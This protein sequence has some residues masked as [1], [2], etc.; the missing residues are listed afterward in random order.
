MEHNTSPFLASCCYL[1][2]LKGE[3]GLIRWQQHCPLL[4][5]PSGNF[6]CIFI[7]IL[8]PLPM[9]QCYWKVKQQSSDAALSLLYS[10]SE[11]SLSDPERLGLG[12]WNLKWDWHC[13]FHC[14]PVYSMEVVAAFVDSCVQFSLTYC[15]LAHHKPEEAWRSDLCQQNQLGK[16]RHLF[17]TTNMDIRRKADMVYSCEKHKGKILWQDNSL[18]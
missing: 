4:N 1:C 8:T 12:C 5:C 15:S 7:L 9:L 16:H 13:C 6:W 14:L 11:T 2:S 10:P 17:L 18:I 3:W